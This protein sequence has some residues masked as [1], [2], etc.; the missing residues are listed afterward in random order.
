[1]KFAFSKARPVAF[2]YLRAFVGLALPKPARSRGRL[3]E[4]ALDP[5]TIL[6]V[7]KDSLA[8]VSPIQT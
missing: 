8:P 3:A 1:L 4:L 7:G 2:H 5:L 6:V